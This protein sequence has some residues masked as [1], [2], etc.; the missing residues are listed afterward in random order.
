M[1]ERFE[2]VGEIRQQL[3]ACMTR[4]EVEAVRATLNEKINLMTH[5]VDEFLTG[6]R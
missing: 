6:R 3:A 4:T 2:A 1:E 5:R